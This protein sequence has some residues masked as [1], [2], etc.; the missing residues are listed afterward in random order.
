M[1][2]F[3][4]DNQRKCTIHSNIADDGGQ[5]RKM[6]S[7]SA[8]LHETVFQLAAKCLP[9]ADAI[10]LPVGNFHRAVRILSKAVVLLHYTQITHI[11]NAS[12]TGH[13]VNSVY[14]R[15]LNIF[16]SPKQYKIGDRG[17]Q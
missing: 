1:S 13:E 14:N 2:G 12:L 10:R 5:F 9:A 6:P 4:N 3:N 7:G 8:R 11:A 16:V 15:F 17:T